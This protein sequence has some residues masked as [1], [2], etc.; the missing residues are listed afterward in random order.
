MHGGCHNLTLVPSALA[1]AG[2]WSES[3]SAEASLSC[4]AHVVLTSS[5]LLLYFL[6]CAVKAPLWGARTA[7]QRTLTLLRRC[8]YRAAVASA[9]ILAGQMQA[10]QQ[11]DAAV[12]G[13]CH[14]RMEQA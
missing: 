13:P 1:H 7:L 9:F 11:V 10:V 3:P 5:S 12:S 4:S 2:T 6:P 14:F 8:V